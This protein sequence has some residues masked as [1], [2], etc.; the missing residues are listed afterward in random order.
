MKKNLIFWLSISVLSLAPIALVSNGYAQMNMGTSS[1]MNMGTKAMTAL[2]KL[3]GKKFDIAW[4]S[5]KIGR[6]HV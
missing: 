6:A 1:S 2:E 3:M 4:M 5:Q